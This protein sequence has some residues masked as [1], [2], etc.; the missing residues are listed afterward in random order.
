MN[1]SELWRYPVKSMQ[2][3]RLDS[4]RVDE[5]GIIGDRGWALVD[6][7]TSL[8]LTA[9][10]EPKLL[11]A[12]ARIVDDEVVVTLPDGAETTEDQALSAW[13]GRD[14]QLRRADA[15]QAGTFESQADETETGTWFQWTGPEGSFHDSTRTRVSLVSR[16]AFRS[17]DQRRFRINVILDAA[18]DVGLVGSQVGLGSTTLNVLKQI[19]RCIM[20]TRPQPAIG[21]H[22][23]VDRDLSVLKTINAENDTFLGVGSIVLTGGVI[24]PGDMLKPS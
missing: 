19:D 20:T 5:F 11:F 21:D 6:A 8:A 24:A 12:A 14:V 7:E 23:P 22:Q 17:W 9:R 3:E 15:E 4:A 10:R 18:G 13:V 16:D 2:G 1:V